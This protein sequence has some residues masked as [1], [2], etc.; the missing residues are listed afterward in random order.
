MTDPDT[1]Q[2]VSILMCRGCCCGRSEKHPATD[3]GRQVEVLSAL[4]AAHPRA[5]LEVVGCLGVCRY[6][7]VVVLA[8]WTRAAW[9]V[10]WLG[11]ILEPEDLDDLAR[12]LERPFPLPPRL[13]RRCFVPPRP[14]PAEARRRRRG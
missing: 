4:V 1:D 10:D 13:A 8:R 12:V 11:G 7:N 5:S 6:S 2:F 9:R 3:H 14:A